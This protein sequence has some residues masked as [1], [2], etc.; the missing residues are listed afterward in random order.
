MNGISC[1]RCDKGLLIDEDVRYEAFI[2]VK[3]AYDPMEITDEDLNRDHESEMRRLLVQ[4]IYMSHRD[5][6]YRPQI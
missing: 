1:D 3:A 6:I 5:W 2:V 4:A